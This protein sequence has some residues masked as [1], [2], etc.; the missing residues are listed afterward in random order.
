MQLALAAV[1]SM[2]GGATLG[3]GI[4]ALGMTGNAIGWAVGSLL[5]SMIG[6]K[7]VHNRQPGLGDKS[8]QVSTYGQMQTLLYGTMRLAGNV[9]DGVGEI[10]EV[11]TTT[12]VGK[13]GPKGSNTTLTWNADIAV[14]LC[15][16]G[17]QGIRKMWLGGKLVYDV[18]SGGTASSIIA[19]S[20][21]ASS[22]VL[23]NGAESQLPDPTLEALHGVGNVPAYRGRSYVVIAGLDCPNGQIPQLTFEVSMSITPA[24]TLPMLTP[25]L[26]YH[27]TNATQAVVYTTVSRVLGPDVVY[28]TI[29]NISA[30]YTWAAQ[31]FKA[32]NGYVQKLWDKT[33][34]SIGSG[35]YSLMPAMNGSHKTPMMVRA[36]LGTNGVY[37]STNTTTVID[38]ITGLETTVREFVPGTIDYEMVPMYA[39]WDEITARFVLIGLERGAS[40]YERLNPG[41]YSVE[42]GLLA[43]VALPA[44]AG[45]IA[46]FY[47]GVIYT[48]DQRS[49]QTYLQRYDGTTG[50]FISEVGGGPIAIS[51][52]AYSSPGSDPVSTVSIQG[53]NTAISAH[54]A[55]V[56]VYAKTLNKA[57]RIESTWVELSTTIANS[58]GSNGIQNAWIEQHYIAE[59]PLVAAPDAEMHYRVAAMKSFDPADVQVGPIISDLCERAGLTSGQI[60]VTGLAETLR[61]YAI[62]RQISARA[63]VEPLLKAFFLDAREQDGQVQFFPRADQVSEFE[64]SYEE[65][66]AGAEAGDPMP[67]SRADES[68]MPRSVT[69]TYMDVDAD[70]QVGTQRA[71]R[72]V[73]ETINE[74]ADELP[75]A[76]TAARAATVADVLLYD[77]WSGRNARS[78]T[79]QRKF[80]VVS[81]G[82]VGLFEYPQG[83]FTQKR[84]VRASDDGQVV[85]L[86]LVDGDVQ[87]YTSSQVG[88]AAPAEQAGLSLIAPARMAIMDIPILRDADNSNG[89]YV[90]MAG[91]ATPWSGGALYIGNDDSSLSI[92]ASVSSGASVGI[93]TTALGAWSQNTI[94]SINTVRVEEVGTQAST[95]IDGA[96]TNNINLWLIGDELLY[97]ITATYVS[98]GVYTLSNLVRGLR[99]TERYRSTHVAYERAVQIPETGQGIMHPTLDLGVIGQERQYRAISF[100]RDLDSEIST[101]FSLQGYGLMPL[102]PVDFRRSSVNGNT[103]M[104]WNRRSRFSGEFP[105]GSDIPI[106]ESAELYYVDV[107]S[108]S[109]FTLILRTISTDEPR[110]TYTLAQQTVDFGAYQAMLYLRISQVSGLVGRG[111]PLEVTSVQSS[112]TAAVP[113]LLAH[114]DGAGLWTTPID[115]SS[116]AFACTVTGAAVMTS[117]KSKF[118][119]SSLYIPVGGINFVSFDTSSAAFNVGTGDFTCE[120]WFLANSTG[121]G[122][123]FFTISDSGPPTTISGSMIGLSITQSSK[124]MKVETYGPGAAFETSNTIAAAYPTTN[125]WHHLALVRRASVLTCY[126]NGVN[127]LSVASTAALNYSASN[128]VRIG[129]YPSASVAEMYYDEFL[130]VR[131]ALYSAD[132]TPPVA[133]Y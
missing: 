125:V 110:A 59:G 85:T 89:P 16:A 52:T 53:F 24:A 45:A 66:A 10:R 104:T 109:T 49:G 47:A 78:V 60:D 112:V 73:A 86:D 65:L 27:P 111:V 83:T 61:G 92:A 74:L 130:F 4:V 115:S 12:R 96:L 118:G 30:S 34:P 76:I 29:Q 22:F 44:T 3:T 42:G 102:Q 21:R 63:A 19:S 35:A 15:Q 69:V 67:L 87:L 103:T 54:A 1:G 75:L 40:N 117:S 124:A 84:V 77:A 91:A 114:F 105:S 121:Y 18:S 131:E 82:D 48:L 129:G 33:W 88:V 108:D 90:A 126:I 57:W 41:I 56:F 100:G 68:T 55:G 79:L 8:V 62:T 119:G 94:D 51:C 26:I 132:F 70:Y 14:D 7:A 93:A 46:A 36:A 113:S 32:G 58:S 99:G 28:Q 11:A 2:I 127:K 43:R 6:Q 101:P 97:A 122:G 64:V 95:T 80:A 17:V 116:Y 25:Q 5:G 81:P 20:I 23:Y 71:I 72:Q 39:A 107:Y 106:G 133:P 38:M 37:S 98:A 128:K 9:V 120:F 123:Y 31:G 50:A 13:G